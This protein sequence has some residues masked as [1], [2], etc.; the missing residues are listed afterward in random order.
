MKASE[1]WEREKECGQKGGHSA[2]DW[3]VL[4][5]FEPEYFHVICCYSRRP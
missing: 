4:P 1:E 3:D 2:G 5:G